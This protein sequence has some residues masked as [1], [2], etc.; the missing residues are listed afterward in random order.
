VARDAAQLQPGDQVVTTFATS[1]IWPWA[2]GAFA[3]V[4]LEPGAASPVY[5][6]P[7]A[8]PLTSVVVPCPPAPLEA[9]GI[10][11]PVPQIASAHAVGVSAHIAASTT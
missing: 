4:E 2:G 10:R 5:T 9:V 8:N 1:L 6:A 11:L 7:M 3:G